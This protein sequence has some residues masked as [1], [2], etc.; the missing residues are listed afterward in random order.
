MSNNLEDTGPLTPA[1]HE[2]MLRHPLKGQ[3][4][5]DLEADIEYYTNILRNT[6]ENDPV[7]KR[8]TQ[9]KEATERYLHL[10]RRFDTDG[11]SDVVT[12]T[13]AFDTRR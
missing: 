9:Q 8:F 6:T 13:Q 10:L 1:Q 11:V 5:A 4:Y 7:Y 12:L 2:E 3:I